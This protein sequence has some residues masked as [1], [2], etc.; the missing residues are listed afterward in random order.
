MIKSLYARIVITF[1]C[2]V[3]I[4]V[5]LGG[6]IINY[7]Y[8]SHVES[9]VQKKMIANAEMIVQVYK[10]VE[11]GGEKT[12]MEISN[13]FPF[14]AV[15]IYDSYGTLLY[16]GRTVMD[17]QEVQPYLQKVLKQNAG[18]HKQSN[19]NGDITVG[20]PFMLNGLPHAI[21]ITTQVSILLDEINDLTEFL[22]FFVLGL[23]SVLVLI[24]TRYIVRP[25]QVLTRATQRMAK[26]DFSVSLHTKRSD[27][28]GQLTRSFNT[29]RAELGRLDTIR[30]R[31]VADVSHEF[32]SPLTSI[33]GFTHVLKHKPMDEQ[34]RIRLLSIIE[35]ESNRLSR[36]CVDLLE[37]S[38][39][40]HEQLRL[41]PQTFRLDEQ[42]R[43]S[44][45]RLEP[46]WFIH[47]LDIQLIL[48]PISILADEDQLN[49]VWINIIGNSIKF[50]GHQ[51]RII[52]AARKQGQ[53]VLV[54]ITDNGIGIAE[55][56]LSQIFKPFYKADKA[57]NRNVRGNGI[58]LSI[59]KQIVDLHHGQV[60]VSSKVGTGTTFRVTFPQ[61][62][63]EPEL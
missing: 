14:Y 39:L 58:G 4:S 16:P 49:Q 27:D 52:V 26:G 6:L 43:K 32:Q 13:S 55:E 25:L 23:G 54:T 29:M 56:D 8:E 5:I 28:I 38:S 33:K 17:Q 57:R 12:L 31:F 19:E 51:G 36:L 59:V 50:T 63:A 46:Q 3:T 48:E 53:N 9:T 7:F 62:F 61:H 20:L 18:Y 10:Q 60:E 40:E 44:V 21:F 11:Q 35:E 1:L 45:I 42:L 24:A 37:L 34:S 30:K 15:Q 41:A 22:Q 2:I 47:N